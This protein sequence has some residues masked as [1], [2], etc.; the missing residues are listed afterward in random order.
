M[1]S[2]VLA[3]VLVYLAIGAIWRVRRFVRLRK[4]TAV[5]R[6]VHVAAGKSVVLRVAMFLV[7]GVLE[8]RDVLFWPWA[9]FRPNTI[10]A[11]EMSLIGNEAA[12]SGRLVPHLTSETLAAAVRG[13]RA[14]VVY[15]DG[16]RCG[17]CRRLNI[18]LS[19]LAKSLPIYL[20]D[21]NDPGAAAMRPPYKDEQ[22]SGAVP[23]LVVYEDGEPLYRRVGTLTAPEIFQFF[24]TGR[25]DRPE[26][27]RV[28][29]LLPR[30]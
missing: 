15:S 7:Y 16:V 12:E 18:T 20:V 10:N 14:L 8:L 27:K 22:I 23:F 19:I 25:V 2:Q 1:V 9:I 4:A 21:A 13:R 17:P 26:P 28:I 3:C 24:D 29:P 30:Q 6:S 5:V 11:V